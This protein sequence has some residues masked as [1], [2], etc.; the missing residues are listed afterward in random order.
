MNTQILV[1]SEGYDIFETARNIEAW[2]LTPPKEGQPCSQ[3]QTNNTRNSR[4]P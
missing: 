1:H 3:P 4:F 2:K